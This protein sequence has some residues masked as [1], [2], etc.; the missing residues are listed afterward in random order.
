MKSWF[1]QD[2][3]RYEKEITELQVAETDPKIDE[4]LKAQG[5]LRLQLTIQSNNPV[6]DLPEGIPDLLLDVVFPS[7]Y[8]YFRPIVY[9]RQIDLK[10]HQN[11]FEKN[12]CL[13]GRSTD[14]W[15]PKTTLCKH[16]QSQLRKVLIQGNVTDPDVLNKDENEQAEPESEYYD[17]HLPGVIFDPSAYEQ[18][19]DEEPVFK[20]LGRIRMGVSATHAHSTRFAVLQCKTNN[21]QV[22]SVLPANLS[23]TYDETFNGTVYR[24]PSR[25]PQSPGEAFGWLKELLTAQGERLVY[26]GGDKRLKNGHLLQHVYA[27]N[28]P[29]ESSTFHKTYTGWLFLIRMRINKKTEGR[30]ISVPENKAFYAKVS[31][32]DRESIGI[33]IPKLKSLASKSVAIFGLGALGAPSAIEFAKSGVKELKLLDFDIVDAGTSVRWPIG[34][35]AA[36]YTKT[37]VLK[38]FIETNYPFT[39]V[40]IEHIRIGETIDVTKNNQPADSLKEAEALERMFQEVSLV[41]DATAERGVMHFLSQ[42]TRFRHLPYISISATEGAVGG[43]IMRVIPGK[44]EGCWMCLQWQEFEETVPEPPSDSSGKIQQ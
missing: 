31:R 19:S 16:L 3:Q 34:L 1:E 28:F 12:L 39:K 18:I 25:P 29:E 41:Y 9:E 40:A 42:Q 27:L 37:S 17:T 11:P 7:T 8:P 24:L 23:E 26:S 13:L 30:N 6:F 44:T 43:K 21:E 38:S 14:E 32:V 15:E 36:G 35:A 2:P 22:L 10:R 33:R 5:I 4:E 20:K